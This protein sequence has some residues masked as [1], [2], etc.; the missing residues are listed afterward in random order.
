MNRLDFTEENINKFRYSNRTIQS[1]TKKKVEKK[2]TEHQSVS[3][4]TSGGNI[5]VIQD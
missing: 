2:W 5:N 4:G 3:C 1:K